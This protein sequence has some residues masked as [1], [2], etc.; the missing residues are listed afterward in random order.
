MSE[1]RRP[2]VIITVKILPEFDGK[3]TSRIC[4]KVEAFKAAHW[5]YLWQPADR[6]FFPSPP[7]P[8]KERAEFWGN[9]YRVR[10][11][12]R[13]LGA[14]K[15][16]LFTRAQISDIILRVSVGLETDVGNSFKVKRNCH[17]F[18]VS[19]SCACIGAGCTE[20]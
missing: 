18:D 17:L 9:M 7:Y 10:F 11:G 16:T 2:D 12:G 19:G 14:A 20:N 4:K 3:K 5:A 6:R 13:W 1:V 8:S 15:Y